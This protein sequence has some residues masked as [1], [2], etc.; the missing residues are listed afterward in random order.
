MT[1]LRAEALAQMSRLK[2]LTLWNLNFSGSLDFLS[3]E[4]GYLC[5]DK[6]PFTCLPS[7][8]V[9][10][11]LV[12]LV[13]PR[14]NI[15]Q[16]W[17]G[18]KV[19]KTWSFLAF[20]KEAN[21]SL[22]KIINLCLS[23]FHCLQSLH[24]LTHLNLSHSKNLIMMP[25]FF[26]IPNLELLDLEGCLK[27]VQI[28]P[29]ICMLKRLS[30]LNLKDC[31]NLVSI[32]NNNFDLSSLIRLNLSGCPNLPN[33]KLLEGKGQTE[34]LEMLDNKESTTRYQLTSFIYKVLKPHFGFS[35]FAKQEDSVGLSLPLLSRFPYL[36]YLDLSF[37]NLIQIP[38]AIGWLHCLEILN[39]G[40]NNFVTL[41]SMKELS[42]LREFN[43]EHCKQLKYLPEL[44][45]KTVLP[46]R[47]SSF[48]LTSGLYIFDCPSLIDV[49]RCYRMAFSWMILVYISLMGLN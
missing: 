9:A 36:Q 13:L 37:C 17:V 14:S 30:E 21:Q 1:T 42:K 43:L 44:P 19:L 46:E 12:E 6:Y 18:T 7:S 48:G 2:L 24:N 10:D 15:R 4:L 33:N 49:E 34:H 47:K 16:L 38:D 40:G 31:K 25:N 3:S 39:L 5:W 26:E 22:N 32:P 23:I 20:V 11:K 28:D 8:F 27:L 29:S 41:P 35:I 45:S